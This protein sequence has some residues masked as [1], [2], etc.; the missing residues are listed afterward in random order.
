[1]AQRK[2]IPLIKEVSSNLRT[3]PNVDFSA[4]KKG[5]DVE[6]CYVNEDGKDSQSMRYLVC[7]H[8]KG[9]YHVY[10]CGFV[11]NHHGDC[12]NRECEPMVINKNKL[13]DFIKEKFLEYSK[14]EE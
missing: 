10:G 8:S 5:D 11:M 1:M 4:S 9:S 12:Y 7:A 2:S 3:I 13:F 14:K 6:I